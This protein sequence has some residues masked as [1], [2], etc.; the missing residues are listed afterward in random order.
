MWINEFTGRGHWQG[1][2]SKSVSLDLFLMMPSSQT[3]QHV[4]GVETSS[5]VTM[6]PSLIRQPRIH[7]PGFLRGLHTAWE[8][9][10]EKASWLE[11][12]Y[13]WEQH[14]PAWQAFAH[15]G[16]KGRLCGGLAFLSSSWPR[17]TLCP[18]VI[19]LFYSVSSPS[20][21]F[22]SFPLFPF[23][24]FSFMRSHF[25]GINHFCFL[26][27][28]RNSKLLCSHTTFH[29]LNMCPLHALILWI[30]SS[31]SLGDPLQFL[32][33]DW[34]NGKTFKQRNK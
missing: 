15:P 24:L 12:S 26:R 32:N 13:T 5:V 14:S 4:W 34:L 23:S 17:P 27:P 16:S 19:I 25:T 30:W 9:M 7:F 11:D 20:M 33:A 8:G 6:Q 31:L 29:I 2:T 21:H 28:L 10:R 22:L 1:S 18:V 3:P